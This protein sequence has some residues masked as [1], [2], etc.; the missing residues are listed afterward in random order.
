MPKYRDKFI[1]LGQNKLG[2]DLALITTILAAIANLMKICPVSPTDTS[3]VD[4][5]HGIRLNIFQKMALTD[6]LKKEAKANGINWQQNKKQLVNGAIQALAEAKNK[7]DVLGFFNE[8]H[9]AL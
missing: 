2:F 5:V 1:K 8:V 3:I 7:E 9:S 6:Q 4:P